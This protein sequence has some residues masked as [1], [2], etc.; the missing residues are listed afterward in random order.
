VRV[1]FFKPELAWPRSSGHDVHTHA[2]M[3]ALGLK[4]IRVSLAVLRQSPEP[5]LTGLD[6]ERYEVLDGSVPADAPAAILN[7]VQE[8]F[9][10]YWGIELAFIRQFGALSRE[11]GAD[12]VVVSGLDVLPFLAAV[13]RSLRVWYAG[14]EWVIHHVSQVQI[15]KSST[16]AELKPAFIK[17]VYERAYAPMIDRSWVVSTP[18]VRAMRWLAGVRAVDLVQNG[19][20]AAFIQSSDASQTEDP[21]SCVFWGRLDFGPNIQAVDWFTKHVWRII[22]GRNPHA[23]FKIIGYKPV[24]TIRALHGQQG[25]E[26]IPDC[27]DLRPQVAKCGVVVLPF[28]SGAGIKNK[29][30][31]AAAMKKAIV[32]SPRA[33]LGLKGA[34]PIV[35][36]RAPQVWADAV[37]R[38]WEDGDS[39]RAAGR[40]AKAWV[41]AEHTWSAAADAALMGIKSGLTEHRSHTT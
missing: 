17:G 1:L 4:G 33:M 12:V 23:T 41:I 15:G 24:G 21:Y 11:I 28:V 9:R 27:P 40:A 36:A 3:V 35:V 19:V 31:E 34:P 22:R 7:R 26:L 39:R 14:D 29:L 25:I 8:R 37:Q 16:W 38:F 30:L 20:D 5:A 2:M 32:A 6:L 10:S 13:E 18:D